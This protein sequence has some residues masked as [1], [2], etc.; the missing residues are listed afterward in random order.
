M[1]IFRRTCSHGVGWRAFSV[2][3]CVRTGKSV[4]FKDSIR[5]HVLIN[6]SIEAALGIA[7]L[8]SRTRQAALAYASLLHTQGSY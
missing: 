1:G 4:A 6:G 5:A 8:N 7:L 3:T 2:P